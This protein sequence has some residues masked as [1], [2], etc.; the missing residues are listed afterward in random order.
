MIVEVKTCPQCG[1]I[2][3]I[4]FGKNSA[5]TPRCRCK[6]C[7]ACRVLVPKRPELTPERQ[8]LVVKT[9]QERNSTRSTGRIFGVSHVTV[10]NWLKKSQIPEPV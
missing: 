6:D 1:S 4:R 7:G 2:N 5:G 3:L 10:Q 9:Y 8:E